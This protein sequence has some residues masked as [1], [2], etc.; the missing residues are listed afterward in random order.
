M[1]KNI[2][3]IAAFTFLFI[4]CQVKKR[5][6]R[7]GY[8]ISFLNHKKQSDTKST[9]FNTTKNNQIK[10]LPAISQQDVNLITSADNSLL[11]VLAHKSNHIK[12]SQND[13]CDIIY[14]HNGNT[15]KAYITEINATEIRHRLQDNLSSPTIILNK[16]TVKSIRFKNGTTEE[17]KVTEIPAK[18]PNGDDKPQEKSNNYDNLSIASLVCGIVGMFFL[19]SIAAIVLGKKSLKRIRES[20]GKLQGRRMAMAGIILGILKITIILLYIFAIFLIIGSIL[21]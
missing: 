4:S 2:F 6:Y 8:D 5:H 13:S 18:K 3:I 11:K 14:L 16:K 19:G 20:E 12:N 17:Y 21:I 7:N 9:N 15:I 1:R 10:A